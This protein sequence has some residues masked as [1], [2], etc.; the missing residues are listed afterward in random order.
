VKDC[1]REQSFET[2]DGLFLAI[3][4]VSRAIG[5][6]NLHAAFLDWPQRRR[7]YIEADGDY[8]EEAEKGCAG[9]ISFAQ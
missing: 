3:D 5:R 4:A 8:F 6:R 9:E 7:Q 2:A 1:L